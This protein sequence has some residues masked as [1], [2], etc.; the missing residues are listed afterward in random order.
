HSPR[1]KL[2]QMV[3]ASVRAYREG[4]Q[5]LPVRRQLVL[6]YLNSVPLSAAHFYG[7]VHGLAD[8]LWVW[9]GADF[10]RVNALLAAPEG[11]GALLAEQGQALRRVLSL[12]VAHRRPSFY[13]GSGRDELARLT[14]SHLRLLA[15]AGIVGPR[16]RDAA[17]GRA[18]AF[19]DPSAA[20]ARVPADAGKGSTAIR[21]RLVELLGVSL[22]DLDR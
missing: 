2:R 17:L 10:E 3:S 11:E 9:Y 20:P 14:D 6:D 19:R 21:S 15:E 16:L 22:Y 12:M 5:T 7:E 8:G 18:L 13:L 4:P 1:E